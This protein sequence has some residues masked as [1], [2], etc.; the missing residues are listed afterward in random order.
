[1]TTSSYLLETARL[2]TQHS[3]SVSRTII[4]SFQFVIA[5]KSYVFVFFG[6]GIM[7][8]MLFFCFRSMSCSVLYERQRM[9]SGERRTKMYLPETMSSTPERGVWIRRKNVHK[10]LRVTPSS[11]LREYS[12]YDNEGNALCSAR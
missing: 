1:M 2:T 12:H 8:I 9:C 3:A 10:P 6:N 4:C 11:M 5:R 7:N